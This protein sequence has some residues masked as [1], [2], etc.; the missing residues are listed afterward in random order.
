MKK[1]QKILSEIRIAEM[2]DLG[3]NIMDTIN[4]AGIADENLKTIN[5]QIGI[6]QVILIEAIKQD[7]AKSDLETF[8]DNRDGIY[9]SALHLTEGYKHHPDPQISETATEVMAIMD[10]YGYELTKANYSAQSALT[11]SFLKDVQQ[12]ATVIKIEILPGLKNLIQK[13]NNEQKKFKGAEKV[14]EQNQKENQNAISASAV[15]KELLRII[16]NTLINYLR[17]MQGV[18]PEIYNDLTESL[19][20]K[21]EKANGII[22]QRRQVN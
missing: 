13:L 2:A 22:K 9:S 7:K 19:A 20:L 11:E 12:P 17:G 6:Q 18:Q 16:N 14:W 21:I 8:D 10:K 1:P 15:K 5:K 3:A 4:T